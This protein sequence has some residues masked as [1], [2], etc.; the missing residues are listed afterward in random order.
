MDM[1]DFPYITDFF[2]ICSG[3]SFIQVKAIADAVISGLEKVNI[4]LGHVEGYNYGQWV[5][6][7]YGNVITHIFYKEMRHFYNLER[8]WSDVPMKQITI[9]RFGKKKNVSRQGKRR[10]L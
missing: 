7:D 5:L 6:L 9:G 8:L 10:E 4:K 1:R 2:V 3:N